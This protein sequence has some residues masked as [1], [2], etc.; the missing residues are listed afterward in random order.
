LSYRCM[1]QRPVRPTRKQELRCAFGIYQMK[2]SIG[3]GL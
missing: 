3:K 1:Q 2:R